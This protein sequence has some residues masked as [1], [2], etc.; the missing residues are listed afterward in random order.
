LRETILAIAPQRFGVD[1]KIDPKGLGKWLSAQEGTITAECKLMTD[2]T[3]RSRPK[4][5]LDFPEG[6]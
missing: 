4:W 1:R 5:Y 6:E 2:R 3:D